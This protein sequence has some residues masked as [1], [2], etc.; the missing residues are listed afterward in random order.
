M[1]RSESDGRGG[2]AVSGRGSGLLGPFAGRSLM[3]A[4]LPPTGGHFT[5][6][7]NRMSPVLSI[8]KKRPSFAV[9]RGRSRV[10]TRLGREGA[11]QVFL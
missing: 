6:A 1:A 3:Q 8:A 4:V 9:T 5:V 11:G 2:C 7:V 10:V